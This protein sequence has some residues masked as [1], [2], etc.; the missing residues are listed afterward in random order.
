[1]ILAAIPVKVALDC[2]AVRKKSVAGS[3]F[4]CLIVG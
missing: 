1:M 3:Q 4:F 2:G